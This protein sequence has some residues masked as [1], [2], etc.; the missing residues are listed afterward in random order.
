MSA[1][2]LVVRPKDA[3]QMLGIGKTTL[4]SMLRDGR[5]E[6]VQLGPRMTGVTVVSIERLIRRGTKQPAA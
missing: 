3:R 6:K 2:P 5:L 4:F 1:A